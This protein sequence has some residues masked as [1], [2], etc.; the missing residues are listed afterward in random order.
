MSW[1][2][3]PVLICDGCGTRIDVEQYFTLTNSG[4]TVLNETPAAST[5]RHFCC[6]ACATWWKSEYPASGTW[7]PAWDERG[8]WRRQNPHIPIRSEHEDQPLAHNHSYYDAPEPIT[9]PE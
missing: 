6:E 5:E 1:R 8:W 4:Q 3:T 7:G 2:M 9:E